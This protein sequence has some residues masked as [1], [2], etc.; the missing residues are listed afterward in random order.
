M[1]DEPIT[2]EAEVSE[3]PKP[4]ESET[5]KFRLEKID[6]ENVKKTDT[7]E[8]VSIVNIPALQFQK[9]VLEKTINDSQE[10]LDQINEVLVEWEK[11]QK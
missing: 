9:V 8:E 11:L 2:N 6:A 7:R 1:P 5:K 3:T 10:Q 4:V